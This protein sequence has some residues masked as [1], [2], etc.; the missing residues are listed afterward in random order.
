MIRPPENLLSIVADAGA[1]PHFNAR[2]RWTYDWVAR[3]GANLGNAAG[4]GVSAATG[5]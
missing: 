4:A 3:G 1:G 2:R 5:K